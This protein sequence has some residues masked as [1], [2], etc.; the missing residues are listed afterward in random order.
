MTKLKKVKIN[1]D[2]TSQWVAEHPSRSVKELHS[3]ADRLSEIEQDLEGYLD[4]SL[5]EQ[6]TEARSAIEATRD[7]ILF[8]G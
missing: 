3:M 6:L 2:K 4:P 8:M 7:S 1:E 5:I